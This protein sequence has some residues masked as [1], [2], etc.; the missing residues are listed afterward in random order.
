MSIMG[1]GAAPITLLG[2]TS[3]P[4]EPFAAGGF[5]AIRREPQLS[6]PR[7]HFP[8]IRL[9]RRS[10][11]PRDGARGREDRV[12]IANFAAECSAL[13]KAKVVSI[14]RL[15]A[16]NQAGPLSYKSNVISVTYP[17]RFRH[18]QHALIDRSRAPRVIS[19]SLSLTSRRLIRGSPFAQ[20]G[21]ASLADLESLYYP[22]SLI[23]ET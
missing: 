11:A 13:R 4:L 7:Q 5:P 16:T 6:G 8:T 19:L 2:S 21:C 22:E 12:L 9:R 10:G 1:A 23:G 20:F 17:A 14:G 18:R 15:A 3:A